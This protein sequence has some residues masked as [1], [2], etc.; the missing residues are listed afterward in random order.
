VP[1]AAVTA[2]ISTDLEAQQS[3]LV[4]VHIDRGYRQH[5]GA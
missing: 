1:E 5:V 3:G 4:E 2:Q